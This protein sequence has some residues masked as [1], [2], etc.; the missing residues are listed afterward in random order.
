MIRSFRRLCL[1]SSQN[2]A[3]HIKNSTITQTNNSYIGGG[4][5]I[6]CVLGVIGV[7]YFNEESI[8]KKTLTSR[9]Y[10]TEILPLL[11]KTKLICRKWTNSNCEESNF[12]EFAKLYAEERSHHPDKSEMVNTT[13]LLRNWMLLM[14]FAGNRLLFTP[15]LIILGTIQERVN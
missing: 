2:G 1:S 9:D 8:K 11:R 10:S 7:W 12:A 3:S 14:I 6:A 5:A 15:V 4:A 13:N